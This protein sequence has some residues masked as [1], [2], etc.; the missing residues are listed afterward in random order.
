MIALDHL[1]RS[2]FFHVS[3][4]IL[5]KIFLPS[6]YNVIDPTSRF[7]LHSVDFTPSEISPFGVST[8]NL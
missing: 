4:L 5:P 6:F 3:T 1:I 7:K 8:V 2:H